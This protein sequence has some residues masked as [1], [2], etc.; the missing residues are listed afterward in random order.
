M[1]LIIIVYTV[2]TSCQFCAAQSKGKKIETKKET[3]ELLILD[4]NFASSHSDNSV[5][6]SVSAKNLHG[7]KVYTSISEVIKSPMEVFILDLSSENLTKMPEE[8][9][10]FTNLK[11]LDFSFNS[12]NE[13]P[14]WIVELEKTVKLTTQ[15]QFKLTTCFG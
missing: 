13:I 4:D 9:R 2:A 5:T 10:T 8:I 3:P 12:I 11:A 7:Y 14:D 1:K 15:F 6:M